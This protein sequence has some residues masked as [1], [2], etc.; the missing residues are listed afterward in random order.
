MYSFYINWL[1]LN[2]SWTLSINTISFSSNVI[3]EIEWWHIII[4]LTDMADLLILLK[5]NFAKV[6]KC[7][8]RTLLTTIK[9][10]NQLFGFCKILLWQ[11]TLRLIT[12]RFFLISCIC[13]RWQL[14]L[15]FRF[16]FNVSQCDGM[17]IQQHHKKKTIF[18]Q[19]H[20]NKKWKKIYLTA[21]VCCLLMFHIFGYRYVV[22]LLI[23]I[24][25]KLN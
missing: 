23:S 9:S 19:I 21:F 25:W 5:I 10:N 22:Q 20:E 15:N 1:Q 7:F 6:W 18:Q 13:F 2:A 24:T 4:C 12:E 16:I 11:L 14:E 3:S 17:L 8:V